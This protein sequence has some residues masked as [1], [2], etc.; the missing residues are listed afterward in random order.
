MKIDKVINNNVVSAFDECGNEIILMG[1]GIGFQKHTNDVV[2][3]EKIDKYLSMT[4]SNTEML[5][6]LMNEIPF[7]LLQT[8]NAI[9]AYAAKELKQ[10]LNEGIYIS[11]ADHLNFAIERSRRGIEF[12]N[13][14][15]W[16]I[17]KFYHLEYE[18]GLKAIEMIE[19]KFHVKFPEDEAGTIALH[20]VNAE[21]NYDLEETVKTPVIIKEIINIVQYTYGCELETT[22]LN[23]ERFVTHL[24]FFIQRIVNAQVYPIDDDSMIQM[25]K[26]NYPQA[27][28]CAS[29]IALYVEKKLNYQVTDEEIMYLTVHIHRITR[30]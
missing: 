28:Q 11:L 19:Q 13:A 7:E 8:S 15:L 10:D 5:K 14:L 4:D 3:K 1:K 25:T 17:K 21:M 2:C 16:E 20:F 24:K 29:K 9:V 22:S 6:K 23:Y 26:K 27:N 30:N 18:I 12:K